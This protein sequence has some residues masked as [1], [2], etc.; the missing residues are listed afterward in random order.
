[1][2]AASCAGLA[3]ADMRPSPSSPRSRTVCPKEQVQ[4]M[5]SASSNLAVR[6]LSDARALAIAICHLH[7]P[8]LRGSRA[9]PHVMG[10]C[11]QLFLLAI[12]W[13]D[14]VGQS[15]DL[16]SKVSARLCG[17]SPSRKNSRSPPLAFSSRWPRMA[18]HATSRWASYARGEG[19]PFSYNF[20]MSRRIK[21]HF[22][23]AASARYI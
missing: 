22:E 11:S 12:G 9:A 13:R 21:P 5:I 17:L 1:M 7:T 3:V 4:H 16:S 14:R 6:R 15:A 18:V 2:L 23:L 19:D 8:L 20:T 10:R